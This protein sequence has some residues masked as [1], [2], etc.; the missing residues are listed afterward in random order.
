MQPGSPAVKQPDTQPAETP[1]DDRAA[2]MRL[3]RRRYGRWAL[4]LTLVVAVFVGLQAWLTRDVVRGA[5]PAF[6][7]PLIDGTAGA[8]TV[9]QWR[10][11][12]ARD[13]Y[14]LYVWATWCAVC[15][16]IQGNVAAVATD[17]AVLT[18][19]MQSGAPTAVAQYLAARDLRWPTVNDE[20][21]ALSR[22]LGVDAVPMLLFVDR[23]GEVRSVTRGYTTEAG[24]RARLWWARRFS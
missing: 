20:G 2:R 11:A 14:V 13:G 8:A 18:V 24:I 23:A 1:A 7:A 16:T 9:Q 10:D 21:A 4:E 17:D 12:H 15:K 22:S 3:R 5:L 19:A 6:D